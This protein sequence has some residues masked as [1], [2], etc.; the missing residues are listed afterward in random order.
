MPPSPLTHIHTSRV[1]LPSPALLPSP[2]T[3]RPR[4]VWPFS[5][6]P[7]HAAVF[8]VLLYAL[9]KPSSFFFGPPSLSI[10]PNRLEQ[11]VS[12]HASPER[13]S[14]SAKQSTPVAPREEAAYIATTVT[15]G[16][17]VLSVMLPSDP[18][19]KQH[20]KQQQQRGPQ[21]AS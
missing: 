13:E 19:R 15:A 17:E 18:P 16:L 2:P 12:T 4:A 3:T 20:R 5:P 14:E 8:T 7:S 9:S 6:A 1:L 11:A 21:P 10:G